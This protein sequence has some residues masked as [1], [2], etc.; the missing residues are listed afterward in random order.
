MR[1]PEDAEGWPM[2]EHSRLVPH[3]PHRWHVQ[4]MGIG[5]TLLLIHGAGGASHSW[6]GL[7]PILARSFHVVTID[8]PGQG[9]TRSGARQRSGL[10]GM[11]NDLASLIDAEGWVLHGVI[12]HSAGGAIAM[13]LAL[14]SGDPALRVVTINAAL[15]RFEGV[16]GWLFPRLAKLLAATPFTADLFAAA[17]SSRSNVARLIAGTGSALPDEDIALYRRLVADRAHVDGTLSMMAQWDLDGLLPRLGELRNPVLMLTGERDSAVP[18]EV[19]DR[20][21]KRLPNAE[22]QR[23][24]GLG[25]LMHEENP[26]AVAGAILPFLQA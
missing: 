25:H 9:F 12:G 6:R 4:E 10:E 17:A 26:Q 23:L 15:S 22:V 2:S 18:P 8:L 13:N 3:R 24:P 11:T 20:A 16:A 5:P 19:S 14:Q 7:A 1:W 21:A